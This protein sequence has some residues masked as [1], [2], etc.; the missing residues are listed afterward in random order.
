MAVQHLDS[1]YL[2]PELAQLLA[3]ACSELDRH[4]NQDGTCPICGLTWPCEPACLAAFT[5]DTL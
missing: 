3:N 2:L 4:V 1:D 5:L